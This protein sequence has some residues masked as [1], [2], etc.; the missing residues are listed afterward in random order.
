MKTNT[1]VLLKNIK[2]NIHLIKDWI[3]ISNDRRLRY[4]VC[5]GKIEHYKYDVLIENEYRL[6]DE[7]K[8]Y[9]E[10]D[11][12]RDPSFDFMMNEDDAK[13]YCKKLTELYSNDCDVYTYI[14]MDVLKTVEGSIM[15]TEPS[16]MMYVELERQLIMLVEG[17]ENI[18]SYVFDG[19]IHDTKIELIKKFVSR[20]G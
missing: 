3:K 10:S 20:I 12:I 13:E 2:N 19:S 7:Y 17:D 6:S 8:E 16:I 5:L 14:D 4:S 18:K 11:I 1:A 15:Y 9:F